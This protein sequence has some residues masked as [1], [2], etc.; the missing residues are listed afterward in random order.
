M[1]GIVYKYQ[2]SRTAVGH[3]LLK[4]TLRFTPPAQ[5]ND[6]FECGPA[7]GSAFVKAV[8]DESRRLSQ[9]AAGPGLDENLATELLTEKLLR[10]SF[11]KTFGQ[12]TGVLSLSRR[13]DDLLMWAHYAGD[14]TGFVLGFDATHGFF[15]PGSGISRDGLRDVQYPSSRPQVPLE[16]LNAPPSGKILDM[17]QVT[18]AF[19]FSKSPVWAHEEEVRVIRR[20]DPASG[21]IPGVVNFPPELV[22]EIIVGV[23]TSEAD[24]VSAF[25]LHASVYPHAVMKVA[26]LNMHDYSMR[27]E[28]APPKLY[29]QLIRRNNPG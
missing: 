28:P 10:V 23:R 13:S 24:L 22:K 20:L 16:A 2:T 1:G 4:K 26:V 6:P 27:V 3:I 8:S 11:Q 21:G 18:D 15:Q 7:P 25:D 29:M 9:A 5:L 19:F 12:I 14:H 17:R